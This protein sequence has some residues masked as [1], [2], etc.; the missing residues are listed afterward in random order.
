[1]F[2]S[3]HSFSIMAEPALKIPDISRRLQPVHKQ[4]ACMFP[5]EQGNPCLSLCLPAHDE[6]C[7]MEKITPFNL[8]TTLLKITISS[9]LDKRKKE[10]CSNMAPLQEWHRFSSNL[11]FLRAEVQRI[12]VRALLH[13]TLRGLSTVFYI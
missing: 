4:T 2:P 6:T 10:R 5:L 1:M 13:V 7:Q 9:V 11:L 3:V 8:V 12:S